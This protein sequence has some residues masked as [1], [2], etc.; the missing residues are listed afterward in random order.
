MHSEIIQ[1]WPESLK[2]EFGPRKVHWLA[3][4]GSTN[5]DMLALLKDGKAG[6]LDLVIADYQ[7]A[8]RGR[9]GD[10][11]EAPAGKNLLFSIALE[12]GGDKTL[13]TRLPHLTARILGGVVEDVLPK[14]KVQAKW[15][16][17]IYL[18]GKK[19][20]GILVETIMIP[21]PYAVVGIGLNVN[22]RPEEFP[23][24][25]E[26]LATS[27]YAHLDCESSRPF[28]LGLILRGFLESYPNKLTIFDGVKDWL[29]ERSFLKGKELLLETAAGT[30]RGTG[31]GLGPGGEL[32]VESAA[33]K[34]HSI[35]SAERIEIGRTP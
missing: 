34:L 28:L 27:L 13:W 31:R 19:L 35:I 33:G 32:L 9:R 11:W 24:S 16:N 20:A 22:V 6:H 21:K 3:E 30:I 4:T 26:S 5:T 18:E 8:G 2:K 23:P 14:Q 17:D 7:T 25:I 29:E 12:L 10:K 1:G 15:P